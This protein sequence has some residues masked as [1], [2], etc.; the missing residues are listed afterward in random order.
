MNWGSDQY[1]PK[2]NGEE[3]QNY[4]AYT[5]NNYEFSANH[6]KIIARDISG[7]GAIVKDKITAGCLRTKSVYLPSATKSI[8]I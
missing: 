2:A 7:S 6:L 3:W 4:T 1:N 5:S 8:Y